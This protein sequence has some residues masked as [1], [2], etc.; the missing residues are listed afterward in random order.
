MDE[1]SCWIDFYDFV[2]IEFGNF[3]VR[4]ESDPTKITSNDGYPLKVRN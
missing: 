4:D 2:N 1:M 3:L